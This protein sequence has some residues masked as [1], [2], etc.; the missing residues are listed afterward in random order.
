MAEPLLETVG[1]AEEDGGTLQSVSFLWR[2]TQA[3]QLVP[4]LQ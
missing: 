4:Y 2:K 1:A 3:L